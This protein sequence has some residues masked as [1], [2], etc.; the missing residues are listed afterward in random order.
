MSDYEQQIGKALADGKEKFSFPKNSWNR[1]LRTIAVNLLAVFIIIIVWQLVSLWISHSRGITFPTPW[2]TS[3]RLIGFINGEDLYDLSIYQHLTASLE[4]WTVGYLLA[5]FI[6]ILVGLILGSFTFSYDICMPVVHVL[7][8]I[9]G[10]AWIPIALLLFGLGNTS[11]IFM[12]FV[13]GVTPI[14]I[15]TASGIRSIPPI[16]IKTAQM[17]GGN[18]LFLFYSIMLPA[19]TL[20]I[21]GGLRIGLANSWRVLIAAEMI[22]GAGIGLGYSIIQSRWSLDFEAA[23]ASVMI[24]CFIGLIVEKLVFEILEKQIMAHM[25][26][27]QG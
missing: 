8:L 4:R 6:G 13:M 1:V 11:T 5:V 12:I 2:Q 25:G 17:M 10:L 24:I 16:Y 7:Q 9:P 15:N 18:R 26:L 19:A 14:I 23:F 27:E 22:V 21:V 20:S 3:A